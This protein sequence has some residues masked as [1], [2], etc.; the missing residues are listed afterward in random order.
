MTKFIAHRGLSAVYYQNSEKAFRAAAHSPFF[1]GIETDLWY[2]SDKKWVCC[3]DNNPFAD[4]SISVS[5]ITYAE[6]QKLPMNLGK[7]G[8]AKIEGESYICTAETYLELCRLGGKVPIIELKCVPKKEMLAGLVNMVD[9]I[10]GLDNAVFI[11]FH[12]VNMARLRAMNPKI[13]LQVLGKYPSSGRAYLKKGYDVDLMY[14]FS[15]G[16]LIRYAH[17]MG[18]EVNLWTINRLSTVR[19]YMLLGVDYITTNCDFSGKI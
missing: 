9:R 4:E 13:R 11:S 14:L 6:A 19:R 7:V 5:E 16:S 10:V 15:S 1:Y 3:H 17:R 8:S 12:Y 2:T 18:H